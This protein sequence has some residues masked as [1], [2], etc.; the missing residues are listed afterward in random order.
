MGQNPKKC[1]SSIPYE[2]LL[3][4]KLLV[5]SKSG[6]VS[7]VPLVVETK[8][9]RKKKQLGKCALNDVSCLIIIFIFIFFN[10]VGGA[11]GMYKYNSNCGQDQ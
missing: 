6:I 3:Q 1:K 8:L 9:R 4:V 7:G 11:G 5:T 2:T 10:F